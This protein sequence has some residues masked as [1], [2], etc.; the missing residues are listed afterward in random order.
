MRQA[1]AGAAPSG[2]L[3]EYRVRGSGLR[4]AWHP[5]VSTPHMNRDGAPSVPVPAARA[6]GR[7]ASMTGPP[8]A[9]PLR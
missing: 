7:A 9:V 3:T 8:G 4:D 6:S 2:E 1:H 5:S